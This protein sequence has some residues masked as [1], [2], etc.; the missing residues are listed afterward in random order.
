MSSKQ[1]ARPED[2][3]QIIEAV[4]ETIHVKIPGVF[5]RWFLEHQGHKVRPQLLEI[6][7]YPHFSCCAA[8]SMGS[9]CSSA[10]LRVANCV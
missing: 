5:P 2:L 10:A 8:E 3:V 6:A 7:Q 4:E 1:Q 9:D